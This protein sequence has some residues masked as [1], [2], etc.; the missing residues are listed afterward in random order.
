MTSN[1]EQYQ[2]KLLT[3]GQVAKRLGLSIATIRRFIKGK[4]LRANKIGKSYRVKESDYLNFTGQEED[5]KLESA[6]KL[7]KQETFLPPHRTPHDQ[8]HLKILPGINSEIIETIIEMSGDL[9]ILSD[10]KEV[11]SDHAQDC[12]GLIEKIEKEGITDTQV[13]VNLLLV[14]EAIRNLT[15]RRNLFS[16][17]IQKTVLVLLPLPP[18]LS[19]PMLALADHNLVLSTDG[20][21]PPH[22]RHSHY[23]SLDYI[24]LIEL[25]NISKGINGVV[26]EGYR[27]NNNIYVRRSAAGLIYQLCAKNLKDVFIHDIP[28][29]PPHSNFVELNTGGTKVN[30]MG[31]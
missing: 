17:L 24:D 31:V 29:I 16:E 4:K 26:L 1:N 15:I 28:H 14:D 27:E 25:E 19:D 2:V 6:I 11:I 3:V 22:L 18:H 9:P 30:I 8:K 12:L 7:K 10:L 13:A 21:L 20:N 23:R 5:K